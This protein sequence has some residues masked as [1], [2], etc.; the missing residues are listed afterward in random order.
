MFVEAIV[1]AAGLGVRMKSFLPKPLVKIGKKPVIIHTLEAL[2]KN[3][4]IKRILVAVSPDNLNRFK[5]V[6]SGY[7]IGKSLSF[8]AGGRTRRDS[9][10]NCL[11]EIFGET[12]FVLIHDAVRPFI[13][14]GL[15]SRLIA[16]AKKSR[17]VICGVPV[18]ATIKKV[19]VRRPSSVVRSLTVAQTLD[20]EN[21]WEIQTPQVFAK[22]L[23][24][25][26]YKRY[27]N[28]AVTDDAS[29][30]EK[31]GQK[32]KVIEGSYFNIKITTPEDLILAK[33]ILKNLLP[34]LRA[35]KGRSNL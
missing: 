9:V 1:P 27:A 2:A 14:Q 11:K 7:K 13:S 32:V 5:E 29:L 25:A 19:A 8:V 21:V 26:A 30:V 6:I 33:A 10:K 12:D 3:R 15:I 18:K 20:R 23:L 16:E 22:S 4:D 24:T 17:A 35:P 31:M 28:R 34:S